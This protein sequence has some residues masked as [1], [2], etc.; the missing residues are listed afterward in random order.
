MWTTQDEINHLEKMGK[1]NYR[2]R[3]DPKARKR[4]LESYQKAMKERVDWGDM[5]NFE[6]EC[7]VEKE[8]KKLT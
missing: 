6:I 5:D 1:W 2:H 3:V 7:Y 8:L 4:L